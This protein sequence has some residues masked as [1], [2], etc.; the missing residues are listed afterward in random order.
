M[1]GTGQA[2]AAV[3]TFL[4]VTG[5]GDEAVARAALAE[6]GGDV[7]LAVRAFFARQEDGT[8]SDSNAGL[9]SD[10]AQSAHAARD[11]E[12]AREAPAERNSGRDEDIEA[13]SVKELRAHIVSAGLSFTD[14]IEKSD[15]VARAKE[16]STKAGASR[17]DGAIRRHGE[18]GEPA[19]E[20]AAQRSG[21]DEGIEA[22]SV[23]ELRA[24]IASVGLS[25]ADCIERSDLVA[26]AEEASDIRDFL[27]AT[28]TTDAAVA[29]AALAPTAGDVGMAKDNFFGRF[30][31]RMHLRGR[32]REIA[33][34]DAVEITGPIS[35][36]WRPLIGK[37]GTVSKLNGRSRQ[38]VVRVTVCIPHDD[39]AER[40]ATVTLNNLVSLSD[41]AARSVKQAVQAMAAQLQRARRTAESDP[42]RAVAECESCLAQAEVMANNQARVAILELLGA[43][44]YQLGQYDDAITFL[45]PA[46]RL[47]QKGI[48]DQGKEPDI[49]MNLGNAYTELAKTNGGGLEPVLCRWVADF[50]GGG[51]LRPV[52]GLF[53]EIDSPDRAETHRMHGQVIRAVDATDPDKRK[54]KLH[55]IA[56]MVLPLPWIGP[57]LMQEV[58]AGRVP[59][60]QFLADRPVPPLPLDGFT[61]LVKR[62]QLRQL[63]GQ[64][65]AVMIDQVLDR[66]LS[67]R[68]DLSAVAHVE[69]QLEPAI[70]Q[71]TIENIGVSARSTEEAD[72]TST[73]T[74]ETQAEGK[75]DSPTQGPARS[76]PRAAAA[77]AAMAAAAAAASRHANWEDAMEEEEDIPEGDPGDAAF[78]YNDDDFQ[79]YYQY[80]SVPGTAEI[81][82]DGS[83]LTRQFAT[84][85]KLDEDQFVD[86]EGKIVEDLESFLVLAKLGPRNVEEQ[87]LP[88]LVAAGMVLDDV[89][90]VGEGELEAAGITK[91]Y[92]CKRFLRVARRLTR[93]QRM[94]GADDEPQPEPEP[95]PEP[96]FEPEPEP[97]PE[98]ELEPEPEPESELT[99]SLRSSVPSTSSRLTSDGSGSDG[100]Y[101]SLATPAMDP[102]RMS[103][104]R[105]G[106]SMAGILHVIRRLEAE[107]RIDQSTTTSDL[108][109]AL[110][111]PKTV[112][113]GWVDKAVLLQTDDDGNDIRGK[114]WYKHTYRNVDTGEE[115]AKHPPGTRSFCEVL[116]ADPETRHFVSKPTHFISHA[117]LYKILNVVGAL[118]TFTAAQ[119]DD[120]PEIYFWLDCFA[121]DEH[122]S[123][124][125]T[126]TQQWWSSTFK[127]AVQA[128]GHTL[129][130]LSPW[131]APEPL[132]RSWCLWELYCTIDT[133]CDFTVWL[134]PAERTALEAALL[135][136]FNA[137]LNAFSSID[138]ANAKA[139]KIEDQEMIMG[140]VSSLPRGSDWLNMKA[141]EAMRDCA[142]D[143]VDEM[144]KA[145]MPPLGNEDSWQGSSEQLDEAGQL[146]VVLWKTGGQH[147]KALLLLERVI[148][149]LMLRTDPT[150]LAVL[151]HK[152]NLAGLLKDTGEV[153]QARRLYEDEVLPGQIATLGEGHVKTLFS[154]MNLA[155]IIKAQSPD[156]A[157]KLLDQA[158]AGFTSELGDSHV[159]T[160]QAKVGLAGLYKQRGEIA[161]ARA[162]YEDVV[163]KQELHPELGPL[164][165]ETLRTKANLGT[166]LRVLGEIDEAK[167]VLMDVVVGKS[168]H[169]GPS[170]PSTL[171]SKY[172]LSIA[173][174]QLG[175]WDQAY[176][177]REEAVKGFGSA[178]GYGSEHPT[179]RQMQES[180]ARMVDDALRP[181]D[182][183]GV[184]RPD[185][186]SAAEEEEERNLG[187]AALFLSASVQS[188]LAVT[189]TSD[190]VV[191]QVELQAADGAVEIAADNYLGRAEL[192]QTLSRSLSSQARSI[193]RSR[194]SVSSS[195]TRSG[196]SGGPG[197][198]GGSGGTVWR[199][200]SSGA[201]NSAEVS[202]DS[203]AAASR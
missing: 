176:E 197:S 31:G 57:W 141:M 110:I 41:P 18:R 105:T 200:P 198:G 173:L 47:L 174:K 43:L 90:R 127:Q 75:E 102:Y 154:K 65:E 69:A 122:K 84:P 158:V 145:R 166:I 115:Q 91:P 124:A 171:R 179:T 16:A 83:M 100:S 4:G 187:K 46:M 148:G 32:R 79:F 87:Y 93:H 104:D 136:N 139:S 78:H 26:R 51:S 114:R 108:C 14:C 123:Q 71:P 128:V 2:A 116:L 82:S 22:M 119:P 134:G 199:K 17:Q 8:G 130:L 160:L 12:R 20:E 33:L 70:S 107:G 143:L 49:I 27:A 40:F 117:W 5:F 62:T 73:T 118:E 99:L 189:G 175:E 120:T 24:H 50:F 162:I 131:D 81:N 66:L 138:V 3:A 68:L 126:Y 164:H 10:P 193:S 183:G 151:T 157:G 29:R 140:S 153:T 85:R 101:G 133:G 42:R 125:A 142:F 19:A 182:S 9:P 194:S 7:D 147:E 169:L 21:G 77:S 34:G 192:E 106:I 172:N 52:G 202:V 67:D 196:G 94:M 6:A 28:C 72:S 181:V 44:H 177:L 59:E 58:K 103:D 137:V 86:E 135:S 180:L 38:G 89:D 64:E 92:H 111:K 35:V 80:E 152:A 146:A 37:A 163:T 113:P 97:E 48:G 23:K 74:L 55:H 156:R 186:M 155:V 159:H 13:M 144:V 132:T 203:L 1:E 11:A 185:S 188:F 201:Q 95:E 190:P 178:S 60:F 25:F 63:T 150:H 15:L 98:L 109:Q 161:T 129:M 36:E 195:L 88:Q 56:S 39:G 45:M 53:V 76:S 121:I 184:A 112:P 61:V 191:A 54:P 165:T 96:Q 170:H 149:A 30:D 168:Q 167:R